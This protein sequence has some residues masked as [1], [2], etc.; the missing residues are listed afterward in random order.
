MLCVLICVHGRVLKAPSHSFI[1]WLAGWLAGPGLDFGGAST[2][3]PAPAAPMGGM[4]G[5]GGSIYSGE[6]VQAGACL[7]D[8]VTVTFGCHWSWFNLPAQHV[9]DLPR[10][11]HAAFDTLNMGSAPKA[12]MPGLYRGYIS[13]PILK[14]HWLSA[15]L[16]MSRALILVLPR[17]NPCPAQSTNRRPLFVLEVQRC[18]ACA[19]SS[20]PDIGT[21]SS[22]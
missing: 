20:S 19:R 5:T 8:T 1:D 3:A 18:C 4:G 16:P 15:R 7:T 11:T 9:G 2:P 12:Q 14:S 22:P 13:F 21:C 6:R 10:P 17:S